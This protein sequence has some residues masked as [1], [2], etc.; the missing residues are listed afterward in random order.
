MAVGTPNRVKGPAQVFDK[1]PVSGNFY[2]R[3]VGYEDVYYIEVADTF[4]GRVYCSLDEMYLPSELPLVKLVEP[5]R[6]PSVI[7]E[8]LKQVAS[9][10]IKEWL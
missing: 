10:A 3:K 2:T 7:R 9:D 6:V 4:F 1:L 8:Q 5:E